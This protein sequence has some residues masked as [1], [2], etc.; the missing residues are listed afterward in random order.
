MKS[1][2]RIPVT[3]DSSR[4]QGSIP[5]AGHVEDAQ[6]LAEANKDDPRRWSDV[7]YWLLQKSK[8]EVYTKGASRRTLARASGRVIAAA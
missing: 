2:L 3:D 5:A 6:R 1:V 4:L 7:S 8:R